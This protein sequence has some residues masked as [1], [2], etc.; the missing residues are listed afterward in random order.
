MQLVIKRPGNPGLV[1]S[2]LDRL[3]GI[4]SCRPTRFCGHR[5]R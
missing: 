2:D 5:F 4:N 3:L 1:V